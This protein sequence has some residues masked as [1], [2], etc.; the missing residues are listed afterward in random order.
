MERRILTVSLAKFTDSLGGGMAYFAL[1]LLISSLSVSALPVDTVSGIVISV[2]GITATLFQPIAG[3]TVDRYG[4]PKL[5][6]FISMLL[7]S[8]LVL[9][10]SFVDNI[11]ELIFLRVFLGMAE[12]FIMVSSLTLV[13]FL[14]GKKKGQ[15]MGIYNTLVDLGFSVSP[16]L[17]GVLIS[18][19]VD[20]VFYTSAMLV[21]I[22]SILILL[23]VEEVE[24]PKTLQKK[25]SGNINPEVIPILISLTF[26]VASMSSIVPLENSFIGRFQ[27][28][29]FEFGLSFTVYLLVRTFSNAYAG[30]LTD[31]YGGERMYYIS[32]M[33]I[34]FTVLLLTVQS[35]HVFLAIRFIQGFFVAIAYV[36]LTVTVA[37]KSGLSYAM[38]MGLLS[39]A[40]TIGLTAGP[41]I[42][43]FLS[44]YLS[45]ESA[46]MIFSAGILLPVLFQILKKLSSTP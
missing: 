13:L 25:S 42:G 2:W 36:S 32:S 12:S 41:L 20:L 27:I 3:K 28:S 31:R 9:L 44:G 40:I 38:S 45:F 29:P 5:V 14:A 23:L 11:P 22:S 26:I 30:V 43:G 33:I 19:G 16:I 15:S 37:E 4:R 1:P 24:N 8:I 10:Y 21:F 34:A 6:L 7:T 35:F 17:A 18:L 39:S 46:Y